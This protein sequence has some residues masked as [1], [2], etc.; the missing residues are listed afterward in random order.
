VIGFDHLE[1][2][3]RIASLGDD[4]GMLGAIAD[5][6]GRPAAA[7]R[8]RPPARPMPSGKTDGGDDYGRYEAGVE[9][10]VEEIRDG[11]MLQA[12]L[13]RRFSTP[14]G[15][16][17]FDAYRALRRINP[18]PYLF[19]VDLGATPGGERASLLGAS[20]ELQVRVRDGAVV[21]RPI[22][23]TRPRHEDPEQDL[24][25]E[26]ELRGDEKE[27]AEHAMLVDLARNDVGRVARPAT[28][29]VPILRSIERYSHVMHLVS[30]VHGTLQPG[31]DAFDALRATFPAG[32]VSG[33]PKIRAMASIARLE[34]ERRGP[35]GGAVG[36]FSPDD[37]ET[38]ITIRSA[39]VIGGTAHVHAGAGIVAD[40]QPAREA[41]EVDHKSRAV[42][43]ALSAGGAS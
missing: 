31:L 33:A 10:L 36:F 22:A 26:E 12:V 13:A 17:P 19:F 27:L 11:E 34:E 20:P 16:D 28:V 8:P 6:L 29:S 9:E 32:T 5:A 41:A 18:S 39:V 40:S 4:A 3:A 25:L 30:E 24:A 37:L 2:V 42:R 23:G 15:G 21:T 14:F 35:Y 7:E 43:A 38:A 1:Q